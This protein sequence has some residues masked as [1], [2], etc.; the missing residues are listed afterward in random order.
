[1]NIKFINLKKI[2][3]NVFFHYFIFFF[4]SLFLLLKNQEH[5]LFTGDLY[6]NFSN[7]ILQLSK[8]NILSQ[9]MNLLVYGNTDYGINSRLVF[10]F[11]LARLVEPKYMPVAVYLGFSLEM[12]ISVF[13]AGRLFNQSKKISLVAAWL[14]PLLIL[15]YTWPNMVWVELSAIITGLYTASSVF[16][17]IAGIIF[18]I[19]KGSTL[20]N[21]LLFFALLALEFY[22]IIALTQFV[23]LI[24][25]MSFWIG[26]AS[27][28]AIDTYSIKVKKFTLLIFSILILYY[29]GAVDYLNDYYKYNWYELIT[30]E[31]GRPTF[32]PL[33]L[34]IPLIKQLV[35]VDFDNLF[36]M[37]RN[38]VPGRMGF[39][40]V[41]LSLFWAFS[42][43]FLN[44]FFHATVDSIN[45]AKLF[46]I[47]IVGYLCWQWA[48]LEAILFPLWCIIFANFL[49]NFPLVL[50][51][52]II[53]FNKDL[54][55][56]HKF[57]YVFQFIPYSFLI[58]IGFYI[59]I[60]VL[61]TNK[62]WPSYT[63]GNLPNGIISNTLMNEFAMKNDVKYFKG[64]V[65]N[66]LSL[67]PPP[68]LSDKRILFYE[69]Q[70]AIDHDIAFSK[71]G[72]GGDFRHSLLSNNIPVLFDV[73]R[74]IS[75]GTVSTMNFY[76]SE[77]THY[78]QAQFLYPSKID[79]KWMQFF[80][81]RYLITFKNLSDDYILL[82]SQ[83]INN[84]IIYLYE[85]KDVNIGNYSPTNQHVSNK[86][87]DS[88]DI[89]GK[90]SFDFKRDFVVS[91]K[92]NNLL[93]PAYNTSLT[94]SKGKIKIASSSTGYS[95]L[96]LP[97][98][99]SNC[100]RIHDENNNVSIFKVN[101][102]QIGIFFKEKLNSIIELNLS[103]IGY[104][105]C[106]LRDIDEWRSEKV[107]EVN[108]Y[109]SINILGSIPN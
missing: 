49:I 58:F 7:A 76:L 98:E 81:I 106:R 43:V 72:N 67:E 42:L 86:L 26:V 66:L 103:F 63:Y 57:K 30:N 70:Q 27:L 74:F 11:N 108:T 5:I 32:D 62:S 9:T 95:V 71:A 48:Y 82:N 107:G 99:F 19:G 77:D 54:I 104:D 96:V 39:I 3:D 84:K 75:P 91:S 15:P 2:S 101:N 89:M 35:N 88:L 23:V 60:S 20:K 21:W 13:I 61:K 18:Q 17:L 41:I 79:I 14:T 4:L 94:Y 65:A 52:K 6:H 46:L 93:L 83:L 59:L 45:F 34:F 80:G 10:G 40:F 55:I 69:A 29:F 51:L 22:S 109:N 100:L 68:L 25:F 38:N 56:Q 50:Y 12:F 105:R 16:V 24:C 64:R 90:P 73:N 33:E 44:K 102:H 37:A 36:Y 53:F 92:I 97:F 31:K 8:D 78:K 28:F 87:K 85:I 1:M 47:A